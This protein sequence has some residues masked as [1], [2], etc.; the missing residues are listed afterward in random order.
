MV[1]RNGQATGLGLARKE[2]RTRRSLP[3]LADFKTDI[4]P[5]ESLPH[6]AWAKEHCLEMREFD[7]ARTHRKPAPV[8]LLYQGDKYEHLEL[9]FFVHK[10][11]YSGL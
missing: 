9:S 4:L 8:E 6:T 2:G 5:D 11:V 10:A 3:T 1:A 7:E